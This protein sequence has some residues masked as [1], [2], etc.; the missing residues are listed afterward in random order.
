MTSRRQPVRPPQRPD[1]LIVGGGPGGAS[2]ACVLAEAGHRV[3]LLEKGHHPRFHIGESLLPANLPLL[4]RL[5]V[6]EAV[7]AIGLPKGGAEFY[8]PEHRRTQRFAF[9]DSWNRALC[10][11]YEVRRSAFDE[12]LIR[13]AARLGAQVIEGCRAR[14]IEFPSPAAPRVHAEHEDGTHSAWEPRY[15]IDASGRETFLGS[16]LGLK[17][18]NARHASC[19]MFAHFRGAWRHAEAARAGDITIF[20]FEHGW[21]WFIPLADGATSVGAVVWP[22]YMQRRDRPLETF[23]RETL[24]LSPALAARLEGAQRVTGVEATGSY[25]YRCAR[26]RGERFLLIGDAYSFIDPVFSTGVLFAM[27][28]GIAA[29]EA[30][31]TCLSAPERSRE[32]LR[33]FERR[34]RHGP[35]RFAWFIYRMTRP[36][37]QSLFMGPHNTL[38]MREALLSLLSG[39]IFAD[40]PL[41]GSLRAFQALYY[42]TSLGM[43]R[44]SLAALRRRAFNIRVESA[45][46]AP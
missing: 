46:G 33:R 10:S 25:T 36:A 38:R 40:T 18:R 1:V 39:D 28:G 30:I 32:A 21:L 43:P 42:L 37:M 2:A 24:A 17:R 29:A 16:R 41:W 15:L 34:V 44:R 22:Y 13:R 9:A 3:V 27:V 35:E 31:G 19:A 23:F 8:S 14:A 7:R 20:W 12:I 6:A 26:A 45:P 11:A 4:E 5:G